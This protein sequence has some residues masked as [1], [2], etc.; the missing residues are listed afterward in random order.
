M[1]LITCFLGDQKGERS[2]ENRMCAVVFFWMKLRAKTEQT[3]AQSPAAAPDLVRTK[4][5]SNSESFK[6][7]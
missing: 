4:S 6:Y 7:G 3:H 5:G 1:M 2:D